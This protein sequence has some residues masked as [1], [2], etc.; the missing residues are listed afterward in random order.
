[1][2]QKIILIIIIAFIHSKLNAQIKLLSNI[3][4]Q[5]AT[6][7]YPTHIDSLG[8]GGFMT[9]PDLT[10]RNA[11]PVKR[12]KQ[13]MMVY[14]Q[15]NDSLYTLTT[16]DVSLNSGWVAMGLLTQ[17]KLTDSLN[18]RLKATDTI[19]LSTRI[20]LKANAGTI[21]DVTTLLTNKINNDTTYL[22]QKADT[23]SLSN[24]INLKTN[25]TDF[26]TLTTTVGTKLKN[27]TILKI[28]FI[29]KISTTTTQ[30][31]EKKR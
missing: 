14:V 11:I 31:N 16:V 22:L 28:F 30:K 29:K 24:R 21:S 3:V 2:K 26:N 18:S 9:L 17:Q 6:S 19:S 10:T 20:D 4:T 1:M 15:A 27:K 5:D 25:T 8:R 23:A 13:G 7:V 12:R